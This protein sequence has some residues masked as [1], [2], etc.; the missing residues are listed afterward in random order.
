MEKLDVQNPNI[1]PEQN[2]PNFDENINNN[3]NT[4]IEIEQLRLLSDEQFA[5]KLSHTKLML[6]RKRLGTSNVIDKRL[7]ERMMREYT[8]FDRQGRVMELELTDNVFYRNAVPDHYFVP[9]D[10][11]TI[12]RD[13]YKNTTINK[14]IKPI[15]NADQ[16]TLVFNFTVEDLIEWDGVILK[17]RIE[18]ENLTNF[19]QLDGDPHIL[20]KSIR[21]LIDGELVEEHE[22]WGYTLQF[23]SQIHD[24]YKTMSKTIGDTVFVDSNKPLQRGIEGTMIGAKE[25]V[26]Y[27]S[28]NI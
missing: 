7:Q 20:I 2:L 12:D 8:H 15:I 21:L 6:G 3:Q 5:D 24:R 28:C 13:E 16:K 4:K 1:K 19:L 26:S 11:R 22:N 9:V 23:A 10:P 18:N 27:I 14:I 25:Y 17:L